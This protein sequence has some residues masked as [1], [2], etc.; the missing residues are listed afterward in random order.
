[1]KTLFQYKAKG[2]THLC[3]GGGGGGLVCSV[4][5]FYSDNPSSIPGEVFS[6]ILLIARK[7]RE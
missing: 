3:R 7:D 6:Y 4:L 5:A 1:M 2:Q